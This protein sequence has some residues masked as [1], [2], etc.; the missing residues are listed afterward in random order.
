LLK[1][2]DPRVLVQTQY[3]TEYSHSHFNEIQV[4]QE[5]YASIIIPAYNQGKNIP[6]LLE[7]INE[8]LGTTKQTYEIVVV[9][10]G[11]YD[12]TLS[13]LINQHKLNPHLRVFS[14]DENR[15]KGFAVKAGVMKSRG[16]VILFIDGD[17]NISPDKIRDYIEEVKHHDIVIGSKMHISSK[18]DVPKFRSFLSKAFNLLV[19]LSTGINIKDTQSGLKAGNGDSL[20]K[21]FSVMLVK[22]YAFDVE[23]LAIATLLK[24]RIKEMPVDIK[25]SNRFPVDQ[26]MQMFLDVA[27]I[28][29]RLRI[30]KWYQKQLNYDPKKV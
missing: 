23:L 12:N 24:L 17:L 7:K 28:S 14:Y 3:L 30:R 27:S 8:A 2:A 15:G 18:I 11:S 20:R 29:Y 26:M 25:L 16:S 22:R 5:V 4:L 10:D 1:H 13:V 9:N 21:I 6:Y 19:R